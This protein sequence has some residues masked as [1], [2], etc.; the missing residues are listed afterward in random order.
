MNAFDI[1]AYVYDGEQ[2]L[3]EEH[4]KV[5]DTGEDD[6]ASPILVGNRK[7]NAVEWCSHG[8]DRG[9]S[10]CMTC[11]DDLE[12]T[13]FVGNFARCW[14]CSTESVY[15]DGVGWDRL[16]G[17]GV[18]ADLLETHKVSV[19]G[20]TVTYVTDGNGYT[21]IDHVLDFST[22]KMAELHVYLGFLDDDPS[23]GTLLILAP[24]ANTADDE[25]RDFYVDAA[26]SGEDPV[27]IIESVRL[28]EVDP[29]QVFCT[30]I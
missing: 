20:P 10:F 27:A 8:G 12:S 17:R 22:R 25:A 23:A 4:G 13:A 7:L 24:D 11:G 16:T 3:C 1:I 5:Y 6:G 9:H 15:V 28:A 19:H 29:Y 21:G 18:W 14:N 26:G 2:L 30:P